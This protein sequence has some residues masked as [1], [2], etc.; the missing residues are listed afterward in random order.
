[1]PRSKP[2]HRG[3]PRRKTPK[4][5]HTPPEKQ[6]AIITFVSRSAR[7]KGFYLDGIVSGDRTA[8]EAEAAA[9]REQI[10]PSA[11]YSFAFAASVEEGLGLLRKCPAQGV[12][13]WMLRAQG[14]ERTEYR[15]RITP[16]AKGEVSSTAPPF[17]CPQGWDPLLIHV[18]WAP[19]AAAAKK[20][21]AAAAAAK[22]IKGAPAKKVAASAGA[23]ATAAEA[24]H[25]TA[26]SQ[27]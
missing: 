6:W 10:P 1:M 9:A 23:A 27:K 21:C 12:D 4:P 22:K 13:V 18:G 3:A 5:R 11:G 25:K 20:I 19:P 14:E 26:G 16:T 24:G 8:A 2:R 7:G 15:A 17:D